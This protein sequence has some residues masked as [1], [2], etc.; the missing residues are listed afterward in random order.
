MRLYVSN[1][2]N[3]VYSISI[4]NN[5][6]SLQPDLLDTLKVKLFHIDHLGDDLGTLPSFTTFSVYSVNFNTNSHI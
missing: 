5:L 6:I 4:V 3:R 1:K 2:I